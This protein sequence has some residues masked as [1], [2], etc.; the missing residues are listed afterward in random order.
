MRFIDCIDMDLVK[1]NENFDD[2]Y[3]H[4]LKDIIDYPDATIYVIWSQR[5][6][7]KTYSALWSSYY[8]HMPSMYMKRTN[9]DTHFL[10]NYST[11]DGD[12]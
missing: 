3:Y 4:L 9:D 8:L 1:A 7:G 2:G 12:N 5:G 6:P 10:C 11:V